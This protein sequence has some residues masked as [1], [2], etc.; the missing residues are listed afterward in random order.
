MQSVIIKNSHNVHNMISHN[1]L[2]AS[3]RSVYERAEIILHLHRRSNEAIQGINLQFSQF[4]TST[5]V[6]QYQVSHDEFSQQDPLSRIW[7]VVQT[8][9]Q[10]ISECLEILSKWD[11]FHLLLFFSIAAFRCSM[12]NPTVPFTTD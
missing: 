10:L 3:R 11:N 4:S 8:I 12:I 5:F 7:S 1:Y 2:C 9:A 6:K